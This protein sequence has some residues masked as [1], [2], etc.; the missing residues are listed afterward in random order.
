MRAGAHLVLSLLAASTSASVSSCAYRW[1]MAPGPGVAHWAT[2][3]DPT[4]QT[5]P[6]PSVDPAAAARVT[7]IPGMPERVC[8]V[9]GLLQVDAQPGMG[10]EALAELRARAAALGADAVVH[11]RLHGEESIG[12][13]S[14]SGDP[15]WEA[16][17]DGGDAPAPGVMQL[18][19]EAVRYRDSIRGRDYHVIAR[20]GVTDRSGREAEAFQRLAARA[21]ALRADLVIEVEVTPA[22]A[23][24]PFELHGTAIRFVQ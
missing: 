12:A 1:E 5:A 7:L 6:V 3:I 9:V 15:E 14:I 21:R 11:V 22:V 19:G 17:L 13:H 18:T 16:M 10:E 20:I 4:P 23:T 2:T 8:E 24:R